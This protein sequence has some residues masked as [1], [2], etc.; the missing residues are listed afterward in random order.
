MMYVSDDER[1]FFSLLVI[2][3]AMNENAI[4]GLFSLHPGGVKPSLGAMC[5]FSL[6]I[7]QASHDL[8]TRESS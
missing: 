5:P 7:H 1:S 8:R 6:Y 4:R 3:D 2:F